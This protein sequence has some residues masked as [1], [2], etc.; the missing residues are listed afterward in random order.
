MEV[1]MRK[2]NN[3][4]S[5][6]AN[7]SLSKREAIVKKQRTFLAI[8]VTVLISSG[9]LLGSSINALASSKADVSSYYKYYTSVKIETGD[10]LWSI[11]DKYIGN[12]NI[13]KEDYINEICQINDISKNEIYSGDYIVVPYYSSEMK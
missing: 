11:A 13:S 12:F 1:H 9:I 4:I 3:K 5:E 6:K 8:L 2:Y 7:E 10:T